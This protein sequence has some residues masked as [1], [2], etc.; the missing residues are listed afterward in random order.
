MSSPEAFDAI[1]EVLFNGWAETIVIYENDTLQ[2]PDTQEPFIYIEVV[3]DQLEQDTF[4]APGQNEWVED[5]AAYFH[6]MVPNGTGS[7]EA[8]AIAK[9][10]SNLFRERPVDS[11]NFQRMS[12]GSGEPGRDFPNFFA[13]TLTIGFDRRDTTGS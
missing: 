7:R 1:N 3:G 5:G 6:V 9:R 13:M 4:G 8:R 10:L 11:M 2:D 12:I